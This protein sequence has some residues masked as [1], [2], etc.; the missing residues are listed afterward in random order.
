[1][2]DM[3]AVMAVLEDYV[4][5]YGDDAYS[6]LVHKANDKVLKRYVKAGNKKIPIAAFLKE[7]A[8]MAS[9]QMNK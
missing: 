1:M 5:T 9:K 2:D 6:R 8:K 4:L 7:A 3:D